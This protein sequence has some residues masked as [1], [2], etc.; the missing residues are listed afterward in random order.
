MRYAA[1]TTCAAFVLAGTTQSAFL[2][3]AADGA[4]WL[5]DDYGL[6]R[7]TNTAGEPV[8]SSLPGKGHK[9][10]IRFG[11]FTFAADGSLWAV[12]DKGVRRFG[13]VEQWQTPQAMEDS[14]SES[15]TTA[16]GLSSNAT[17]KVIID[18]ETT[19]W[20]RTNSG[21]FLR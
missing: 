11:D 15:F 3:D 5:S 18:R 14:P 1:A 20:V 10:N 2:H 12:T 7:V 9:E 21:L 4:I 13:H 19:V 16:Q 6:R 17:W 8:V